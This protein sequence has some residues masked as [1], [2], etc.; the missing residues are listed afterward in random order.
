MGPMTPMKWGLKDINREIVL[1]PAKGI[2]PW[3]LIFYF[4][5][6]ILLEVFPLVR[7]FFHRLF[8]P[9]PSSEYVLASPKNVKVFV[10]QAIH[11]RVNTFDQLLK[12]L[13]SLIISF[14]YILYSRAEE[15]QD[16]IIWSC[17]FAQPMW[18]YFFDVFGFQIPITKIPARWSRSYFSICHFEKIG[19][20]SGKLWGLWDERNNRTV[21]GVEKSSLW[22]M[23]S[24]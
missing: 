20:F 14:C 10:W 11:G 8:D 7:S 23:I 15:N 9:S 6:L 13:S 19:D 12:K 21:R 5:A 16:H 3:Y 24:R 22:C 2:R 17:D 18:S 1:E 4:G